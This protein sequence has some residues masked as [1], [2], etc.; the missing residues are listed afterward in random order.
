MSGP[1][2]FDGHRL[3]ARFRAPHG[4]GSDRRPR[5]GQAGQARAGPE[6]SACQDRLDHGH[7]PHGD[8]R[9]TAATAQDDRGDLRGADRRP[10]A[11]PQGH[12]RLPQREDRGIAARTGQGRRRHRC[13]AHAPPAGRRLSRTATENGRRPGFHDPGLL[14]L[15]R[16]ASSPA[17]SLPP[18]KRGE[19]ESKNGRP[20]ELTWRSSGLCRKTASHPR[21]H[22]RRHC[23]S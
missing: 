6:G 11:A 2:A 18:N 9:R 22:P 12:H 8:L 10:E 1:A 16:S 20:A 17:R 15:K 19:G 4:D 13:S 7:G 14:C 23:R 5:A 21:N 3:R